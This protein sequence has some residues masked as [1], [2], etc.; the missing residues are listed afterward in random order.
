M[1][2]VNGPEGHFVDS[3]TMTEGAAAPL[4]Q[5]LYQV[6]VD[7]KFTQTVTMVSGD[8]CNKNLGWKGGVMANLEKLVGRPLQRLVCLLHAAELPLRHYFEYLDGPTTG[9][10]TFQGEIGKKVAASNLIRRPI[11]NFT[12]IRGTMEALPT[13]IMKKL[14]HDQQYFHHM[15]IAIQTGSRYFKDHPGLA[16]RTP[17][18]LVQSQWTT[19]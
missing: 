13:E 6:L 8:G 11:L 2:Y 4:A 1:T 15:A 5:A 19:L 18:A 14:S 12:R 10:S 9:L 16:T 7:T 17:G 3:L